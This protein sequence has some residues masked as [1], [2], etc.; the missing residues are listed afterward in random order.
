MN[1]YS[2]QTHS[3]QRESVIHFLSWLLWILWQ[4]VR[5]PL[6]LLLTILEPVVSFVLGLLA[7][8]GVLMSLFWWSIGVPHFPFVLMLGT[9]L[10][11]GAML[12]PY[13]AL[14]RLLGR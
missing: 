10:G 6:L 14:L 11:V 7:L 3:G 1:P 12:I 2:S 4:C 9:S 5:L 13:Y 8:L